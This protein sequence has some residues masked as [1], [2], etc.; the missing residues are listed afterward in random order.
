MLFLLLMLRPARRFIVSSLNIPP[1][2]LMSSLTVLA[3]SDA[4]ESSSR[5]AFS[6]ILLSVATPSFILWKF[7]CAAPMFPNEN[8]VASK[9]GSAAM[10]EA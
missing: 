10:S 4:L 9:P 7:S 5:F 6:S 8:A 2:A 1:M 3:S